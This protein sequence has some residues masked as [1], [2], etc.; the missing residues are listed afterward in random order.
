MISDLSE[1][2]DCDAISWNGEENIG[3]ETVEI[4]NK[5]FRL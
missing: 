5:L 4:F 1:R 2:V 3:F